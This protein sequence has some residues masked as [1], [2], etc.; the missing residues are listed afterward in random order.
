MFDTAG[1]E[2]V[3]LEQLAFDL[4][5]H[6]LIANTLQDFAENQ[7]DNRQTLAVEFHMKPIG[8]GI[9]DALEVVDPDRGVDDDHPL[10]RHPF[11]TG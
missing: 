3:Q 11:E 4:V 5:R 1:F 10:L 8:F 6:G 2:H 7:V 9:R